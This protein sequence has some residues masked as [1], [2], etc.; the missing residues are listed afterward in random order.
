[1]MP[2]LS[3]RD[4]TVTYAENGGRLT[5]ARAV[6]FDL[7]CGEALGL[8]G[9]SGS[10]KSTIA[11]AILGLLGEGARVEGRIL[12]E[13]D[14]LCGLDSRRRRKLLGRRIGAVFQ[15]PFTTLNPAM[16]VGR[17]I[18][19]PLVEHLGLRPKAAVERACELLA[20][21]R[22]D[23]PRRVA[24]AYPH[25]LSGGMQQRALIAAALACEPPLLILDEPTTALDVTVEAQI[26]ALL[27]DLRESQRIG[28]L[29]IS[30]NLAVVR[31]LCDRIAVFYASQIVEQG[32]ASEVL[33]RPLHPYGKGLVA[34]L[35]PLRPAELGARLPSIGGRQ[36]NLATPPSGCFFHPRCAF[37]EARCR[38]EPQALVEFGS[39]RAV[40]CWKH[41]ATGDWPSAAPP[42]LAR[43]RLEEGSLMRVAGLRKQF[44]ATRGVAALALDWSGRLP[45]LRY[46]REYTIAVDDVSLS[47]AAGE[48]LGLV[49]ESGCG[50][51][52]LGRLLLHLIDASSGDIEFGGEDISRLDRGALRRFRQGAQI[53]FQNADSSLNP[54]LSIGEAIGRPLQ[55]FDP[56]SAAECESRVDKLLDM[57]QLPRAYRR[58]YPFQLSGGERQRVAIARALA[59][60]PRFI[61]CDEPVSALDVSVQAAIVNLLAD[62]RD[63]FGLAYLFISHDLAV[64]GQ[65]AERIAVMFRGS[66]CEIGSASDIFLSPH[67]PYTVA[68]LAAAAKLRASETPVAALTARATPSAP[69]EARAGCRF[70]AH[71]PLTIEGL[72]DTVSPP[73]R[74]LSPTHRVACHLAE[75]SN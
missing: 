48:T 3:V 68:L 31:A 45:R 15:D 11:G 20:D 62:L 67:H 24:A 41:D 53:V 22:I 8:V 27:A 69:G 42:R 16:T 12:F 72:C 75:P 4:L 52:T 30:H 44:P 6:S 39:R 50:K 37:A 33:S 43:A 32:L 57:V 14:D 25:Q 51:S 19:E 5:A 70:Q 34:S 13:D 55:L 46:R 60:R 73:L 59:T 2:L 18:A 29:F 23:Q 38:A 66:I 40:R 54:R 35:P 74:R 65:L 7:A 36:A 61:V 71:C 17:H 21:M 63:A 58:R 49:G 9:E 64:V 1:M 26:L 10:G 47:I 28:L 56:S